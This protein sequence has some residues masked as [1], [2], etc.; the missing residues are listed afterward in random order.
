MIWDE[1]RLLIIRGLMSLVNYLSKIIYSYLRWLFNTDVSIEKEYDLLLFSQRHV[2]V[3]CLISLV[4]ILGY[5]QDFFYVSVMFGIS[6]SRICIKISEWMYRLEV[7]RLRL[8]NTIF[9]NNK[10][11]LNIISGIEYHILSLYKVHD[12]LEKSIEGGEVLSRELNKLKEF[13]RSASSEAWF[14]RSKLYEEYIVLNK[15]HQRKSINSIIFYTTLLLSVFLSYICI[16]PGGDE[17]DSYRPYRMMVLETIYHTMMLIIS[18][19]LFIRLFSTI[20][21]QFINII[22]YRILKYKNYDQMISLKKSFDIK[23]HH[24]INGL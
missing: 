16:E 12:A 17:D 8:I 20:V 11:K 23:F 24:D 22:K 14:V 4:Y 18:Y 13:T 21:G 15:T 10:C 19:I 7:S 1:L 2:N 3:I 6:L 5:K 9:E